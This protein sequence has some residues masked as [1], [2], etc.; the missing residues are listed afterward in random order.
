MKL[1]GNLNFWV[2]DKI[3]HKIKS[4]YIGFKDWG[5]IVTENY[6]LLAPFTS[7]WEEKKRSW[8]YHKF[9]E[10]SGLLSEHYNIRCVILEDSYSFCDML[11]LIRHCRLLVG[12]DSA[13]AIIAQSF[14]KKCF[15]I[16]GAASGP[17]ARAKAGVQNSL[18]LCLWPTRPR[19]RKRGSMLDFDKKLLLY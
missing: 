4:G 7:K 9:V 17:R 5:R 3:F 12:N 13:P 19:R 8:G 16:F 15:V 2:S 14:E 11:S 18:F 1:D 6:I 10:L